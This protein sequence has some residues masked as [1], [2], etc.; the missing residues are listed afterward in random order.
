MFE[1]RWAVRSE[2]PAT[3][4]CYKATSASLLLHMHRQ[5][6]KVHKLFGYETH[7]KL[8][9]TSFPCGSCPEAS[10]THLHTR[11]HIVY[12]IL[13]AFQFPLFGG[14]CSSFADHLM[15]AQITL[16]HA[17]VT[18]KWALAHSPTLSLVVTDAHRAVFWNLLLG[19]A[20]CG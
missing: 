8:K 3:S 7:L 13:N 2:A 17:R 11:A 1:L 4:S 5:S 10:D 19:A 14:S 16:S 6:D 15:W 20:A 12:N 18:V 9:A